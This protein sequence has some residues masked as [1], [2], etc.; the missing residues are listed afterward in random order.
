MGRAGQR[1]G[2]CGER[3]VVNILIDRGYK[4]HR[5]IQRERG[6]K[7]NPDVEARIGGRTFHCEV[8]RRENL[9]INSAFAQAAADAVNMTPCVISRKSR[10]PWLI[11]MTLDDFLALVNE[12]NIVFDFEDPETI[13]YN[14][15]EL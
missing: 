2:E 10:R 14:S 5:N 6:G 15:A 8:K 11:T 4:A 9:C 7:G 12:Q 1:K 3:E 13:C